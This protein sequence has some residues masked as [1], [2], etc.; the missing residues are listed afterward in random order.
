MAAFTQITPEQPY[1][2]YINSRHEGANVVLT[3]RGDADVKE[4]AKPGTA[5]EGATV[6]LTIPRGSWDRFYNETTRESGLP[7][8]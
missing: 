3:I 5:K 4:D 8:G 2:G 1:P 6:T 7:Q